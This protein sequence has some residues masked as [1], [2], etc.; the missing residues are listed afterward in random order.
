MENYSVKETAEILGITERAV[1]KR[2]KK[3][4]IRKKDNKYLIDA[5]LIQSWKVEI[6]TSNE[7]TNEPRTNGSQ[8]DIEVESLKAKI[9]DLEA[10]LQQYEIAE[11]ERIEV[12][13]NENYILFETRLKE[14]HTQRQ[15]IEHQEQI[16]NAEKKSLNELYE[17]YKSQFHYQQ[18]QNEKVLEMH[19]KLIDV[20]GEQNKISIQRQIIEAKEKDV[21]ND[22][23]KPK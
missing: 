8:L 6:L 7:P 10:E 21:I 14:W 2:C 19:Q 11:N 1:Q 9:K 3:D 18:K 22:Q 4:K 23:W 5:N 12:F 16:F 17:H 20:I 15:E 13:T